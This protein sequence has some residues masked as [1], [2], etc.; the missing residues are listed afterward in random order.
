MDSTAVTG[1]RHSRAASGDSAHEFPQSFGGKYLR[2][3][4]SGLNSQV[5]AS[6]VAE[7][8]TAEHPVVLLHR[9]DLGPVAK[10]AREARFLWNK[11]TMT[12][13]LNCFD[14]HEQILGHAVL[15]GAAGV[16][17]YAGWHQISYVVRFTAAGLLPQ[18]S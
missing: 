14:L 15:L 3:G 11:Y 10:L 2:K 5:A 6:C 12:F 18:M 4:S 1:R 9:Q 8:D 7:E 13:A 16:A 17:V